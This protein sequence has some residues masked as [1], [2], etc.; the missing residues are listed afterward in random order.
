MKFIKIPV[1]L[2]VFVL[3]TVGV[4]FCLLLI[5]LTSARLASWLRSKRNLKSK[6]IKLKIDVIDMPEVGRK[7]QNS[8]NK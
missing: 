5:E 6:H 2:V 3:R 4:V 8:F 7:L 1:S